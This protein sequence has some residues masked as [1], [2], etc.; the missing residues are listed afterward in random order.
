MEF[1]F[2]DP[3]CK[4]N[5]CIQM[6]YSF[7]NLYKFLNFLFLND[8]D[9]FNKLQ[10]IDIKLQSLITIE[11][12]LKYAHTKI[13]TF[14]SKFHQLDSTIFSFFQKLNDLDTKI[15]SAGVVRNK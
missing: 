4:I 2:S 14:D 12:D 3:P 15:L 7:D 6:N 1:L 5:E 10:N 11:E 9:Y 8:K 13:E